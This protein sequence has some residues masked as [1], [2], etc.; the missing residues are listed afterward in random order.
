MRFLMTAI[1]DTLNN[2]RPTL[3]ASFLL[4]LPNSTLYKPY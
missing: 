3:L 1:H 2:N 4:T